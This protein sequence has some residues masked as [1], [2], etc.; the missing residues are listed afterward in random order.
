MRLRHYG[1]N[2]HHKED[3]REDISALSYL[4]GRFA[5]WRVL[6]PGKSSL[7]SCRDKVSGQR[8][9]A[10]AHG[11]INSGRHRIVFCR[12][13]IFFFSFSPT[14]FVSTHPLWSPTPAEARCVF[15]KREKIIPGTQTRNK[16][17]QGHLLPNVPHTRMSHMRCSSKTKR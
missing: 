17:P 5:A 11:I 1:C 7:L 10:P 8:S 6:R 4:A 14:R 16:S 9:F 12:C 15:A 2:S 13:S 3:R